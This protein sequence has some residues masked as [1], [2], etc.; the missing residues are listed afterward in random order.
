VSLLDRGERSSL[1]AMG[2]ASLARLEGAAP[3]AGLMTL[4]SL[5]HTPC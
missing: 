2:T 5:R 3:L 4:R 1:H